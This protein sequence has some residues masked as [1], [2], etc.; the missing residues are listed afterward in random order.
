MASKAVEDAASQLEAYERA[1][2][3][4]LLHTE[5]PAR[6]PIS[7]MG[8]EQQEG[9]FSPRMLDILVVRPLMRAA[10]AC[11]SIADAIVN[12]S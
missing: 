3:A 12:I 7:M 8:K 2:R 1:A 9:L 6:A 11:P 10:P 4:A 5:G